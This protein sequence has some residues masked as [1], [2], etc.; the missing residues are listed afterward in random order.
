MDWLAWLVRKM[1]TPIELALE[2]IATG[3]YTNVA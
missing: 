2:N 3:S 1:P